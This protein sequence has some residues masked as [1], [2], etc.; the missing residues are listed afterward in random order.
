MYLTLVEGIAMQESKE[1]DLD[2]PDANIYGTLITV[3]NYLCAM[4][5]NLRGSDSLLV[6]VY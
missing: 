5:L 2:G 4:T 3:G 1:F 6:R